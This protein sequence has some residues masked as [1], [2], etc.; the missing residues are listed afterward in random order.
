MEHPLQNESCQLLAA[1]D[2]Q[3]KFLRTSCILI[4]LYTGA[5]IF[6]DIGSLKVAFIAGFSVDCGT[7]IYPFTFT[8][9]DMVHKKL[10]KSCARTLIIVCAFLN[11]LMAAFFAL[12]TALPVDPTW[13]L[14]AEW[15]AILGP[16]WRIVIASICAETVSELI[17][18]EIYHLWVTKVTKKHLWS[19]VLV[20][21]AV[22]IPVDSLIFSMIAF[23]GTMEMSAVIS[24]F[25]AN[26]IIKGLVTLISIPAIYIGKDSPEMEK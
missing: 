16:V 13:T 1:N 2:V 10:G 23:V 15:A 6:A 9:R 4:A 22:S 14:Q 11:L 24:I 12:V 18:T 5:Q 25:W 21:N 19:R 17:D 26:V 7:F 3:K 20:S 8:L